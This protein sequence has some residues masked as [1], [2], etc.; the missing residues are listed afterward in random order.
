MISVIIVNY[1]A[2]A[3]LLN[4]VEA[5]GDDVPIAEILVVDNASVDGSALT[6]TQRY[7]H[8]RVVRSEENLGFAGGANLGAAH[9]TAEI[10]IFL[11]PD[12]IPGPGCIDELYQE[13]S[14]R[15]GV[16]GPLVS[17][18]TNLAEYGLTI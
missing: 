2:G 18:G 8:V 14:A 12:T 6:C 3:E 10:L 9:A 16:A 15:D 5:L 11:N 1:N 4:C 7:P 17:V 13:L